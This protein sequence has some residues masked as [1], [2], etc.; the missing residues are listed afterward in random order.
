MNWLSYLF[1]SLTIGLKCWTKVVYGAEKHTF[2]QRAH[3]GTQMSEALPQ[4][5]ANDFHIGQSGLF[6]LWFTG[7]DSGVLCLHTKQEL[8]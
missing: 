7:D 6:P 2:I 4:I 5:I 3:A 8:G 1:A